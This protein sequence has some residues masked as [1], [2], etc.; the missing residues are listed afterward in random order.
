MDFTDFKALLKRVGVSIRDTDLAKTFEIMD[1]QQM[2]RLSYNDF[3]DVIDKNTVL[4]IEKIV[5]KHRID[6][7]DA[8]IEGLDT[9][10]PQS[11]VRVHTHHAEFNSQPKDLGSIDGMS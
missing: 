4:P 1:L 8:Y 11:D 10:K 9:T 5:R 6:R 2:G 7:G 3:C